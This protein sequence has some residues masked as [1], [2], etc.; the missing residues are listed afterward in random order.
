MAR[1]SKLLCSILGTVL[2][3]LALVTS[4]AS[5]QGK[6]KKKAPAEE[7]P[8]AEEAGG[9]DALMEDATKEKPKKA[10]KKK[11]KKE[12]EAEA[13]E[14][15]R[16]AEEAKKAAE[17]EELAQT[18]E[19]ERPPEEKAPPPKAAPKVVE[20]PFAE[21]RPFSVGLLL[22]YG[23]KTDR[24]TSGLGTDPYGFGFGIR[25]GYTLD[26]GLYLGVA[27]HYYLG[28]S[29]EGGGGRLGT[30]GQTTSA[31]YM[32]FGAEVGYEWWAGPVVIRPSLEIGAAIAFTD[33]MGSTRS[34]GDMMFGPGI[35][36]MVPLDEWF[37]GGDLRGSVV[38]GN[39]VGA[40][41]LM[42]TGGLRF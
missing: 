26:F 33:A 1:T 17:A 10:D 34:V 23:F 12:L 28:T 16:L 5:A 14:E 36:V 11:T 7:A 9:V 38:M 21:G 13:A 35:T 22:G 30:L 37:I 27:F 8:A 42:A 3:S 39:G 19:W 25:G 40:V 32:Q 24:A 31:S 18:D 6:K 4:S 15:A 41:S 20:P 2:V 29:S